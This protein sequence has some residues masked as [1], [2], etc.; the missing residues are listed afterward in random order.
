MKKAVTLL[1]IWLLAGCAAGAAQ[2]LT[3]T[4][5]A[6]V[7]ISTPTTAPGQLDP[8]KWDAHGLSG[9]L[10][11]PEYKRDGGDLLALDLATGSQEVLFSVPENGWVTFAA[12]SPDNTRIVLSYAPPP[13]NNSP[14]LGYTDLYL[15]PF[16]AQEPLTLLKQR[17]DVQ[18]SYFTPTWAKDGQSIVYSHFFRSGTGEQSAFHYQI[19]R[20][21]LTG[22]SQTVVEDALWPSLSPDGLRMTYLSSA[23][24]N[25]LYIANQDGSQPAALTLQGITQPVDAHLFSPDGQFIYYSKV[26][27]QAST[28]SWWDILFRIQVV[29]AHNVPSDWYRM[30]VAGGEEQRLTNLNDTGLVGTFSPEGRYLAFISTSGLKVLDTTTLEVFQL[31]TTV[32][33]GS[34][35]WIK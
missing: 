15:L 23:E 22:Q 12:I 29:S 30:P 34:I 31:S 5:P 8:G 16:G 1:V 33:L 21:D 14:Q 2:P 3:S 9:R 24:G 26:N 25:D 17:L 20:T 11:L 7:K 27:P 18:E 19:E 6:P 28:N 10:V 32:F 13:E 35:E 4:S